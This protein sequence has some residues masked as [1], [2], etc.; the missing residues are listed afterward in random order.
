MKGWVRVVWE[1]GS[2]SWPSSPPSM[3]RISVGL[4]RPAGR[5]LIGALIYFGLP[6]IDA[7]AKDEMRDK[8]TAEK[9]DCWDIDEREAGLDYC[10]TGR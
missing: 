5:G 2:K 9:W 3:A 7:A 4:A 8:F 1:K 6:H 10:Q